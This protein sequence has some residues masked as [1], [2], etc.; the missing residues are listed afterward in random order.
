MSPPF[1]FLPLLSKVQL[2]SST[3]IHQRN[4]A[5]CGAKLNVPIS[6]SQREAV[7]GTEVTVVEIGW[8]RGDSKVGGGGGGG[9]AARVFI[10]NVLILETRRCLGIIPAAQKV[11]QTELGQI[12]GARR[13]EKTPHNRAKPMQGEE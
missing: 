6:I 5:G 3:A 9:G 2:H 12:C 8:R 1:C 11:F 13:R 4:E 10:L 7:R